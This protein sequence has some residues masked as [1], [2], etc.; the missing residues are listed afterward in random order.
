MKTPSKRTK[1]TALQAPQTR[2]ELH[3]LIA[4]LTTAQ[5]TREKAIAERDAAI[6]E[7]TAEIEKEHGYN[8]TIEQAN[9][10]AARGLELLEL[11]ATEN[12]KER[13]AAARSIVE[14]NARFGWRMGNWSVS[15]ARK[16]GPVLDFLTRI[17]KRGQMADATPRQKA[18]ASIAA[19]Y[20]RIK[21]SLDKEAALAD[22]ENRATVILLR[23]AGATFE[24]EETFFFDPIR[25]G[26]K[27]PLMTT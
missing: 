6:L 13:F 21:P 9:K 26:Q 19:R 24:Q 22:R 5:I 1:K 27:P 2:E 10:D 8:A 11:W 14:A 17:I 3:A 18:R 25:E 7:A 23:Q 16:P 20:L 4:S 12:K 15:T